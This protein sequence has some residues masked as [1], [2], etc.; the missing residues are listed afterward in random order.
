LLIIHR[1]DGKELRRRRQAR[2]L[3]Q[4]R[5]ARMII[6]TRRRRSVH[7]K[8]DH[9]DS[10]TQSMISQMERGVRPIPRGERELV[11]DVIEPSIHDVLVDIL[12]NWSDAEVRD[13]ADR[14]PRGP[15]KITN[16]SR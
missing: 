14:A 9:L 3:T 6:T 13:D 10:I 16:A 4:D 7:R 2:G 8:A 11:Q 15:Y 5:L 12:I 1:V